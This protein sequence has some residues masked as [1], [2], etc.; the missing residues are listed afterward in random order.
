MAKAPAFQ[1]YPRDWLSSSSTRVMSY[2]ERGMYCELLSHQWLDGSI[3][4]TDNEISRLLGV[5]LAIWKK[6]KPRVVSR[7]AVETPTGRLQNKRL[8]EVRAEQDAFREERSQSGKKGAAIRWAK[9]QP[10][11][12]DSSAM[13]QPLAKNGSA[14]ATATVPAVQ[15][16]SSAREVCENCGHDWPAEYGTKCHECNYSPDVRPDQPEIKACTCGDDYRNSYNRRCLDCEGVPSQ[17]QL[18]ARR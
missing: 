5:T 14:P 3:P 10:L 15:S 18:D 7:F 17:E 12:S 8:E 13:K 1:F 16:S 9:A 11:N 4:C 6:A 2:A